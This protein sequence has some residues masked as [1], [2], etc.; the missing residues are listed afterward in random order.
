MGDR[1]GRANRDVILANAR[2]AAGAAAA[3]LKLAG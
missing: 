2:L 1:S 3:W